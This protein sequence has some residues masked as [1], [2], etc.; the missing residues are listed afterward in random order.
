MYTKKEKNEFQKNLKLRIYNW[1]VSLVKHLLVL[2]K[3]SEKLTHSIIDQVMRSGTSV[4]ANYIEA[5]GAPT[6]K[7]FRRFLSY[8]LKSANETKFWLSL[9][10]HTNIDTSKKNEMLLSENIELANI[11]GKSVS[12]LYKQ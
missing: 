2:S 5:I 7:D 8:S 11:L 9:M 12:T 4:G 1:N 10:Q 6:T 3:K